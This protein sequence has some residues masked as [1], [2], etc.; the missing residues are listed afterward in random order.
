MA[1][2]IRRGAKA[3]VRGA[4]GGYCGRVG[5]HLDV[6]F[7]GF[8]CFDDGLT[9]FRLNSNHFRSALPMIWSFVG[10]SIQ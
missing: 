4:G 6:V 1:F 2:S 3:W 10:R 8:K 5:E 9:A 7:S